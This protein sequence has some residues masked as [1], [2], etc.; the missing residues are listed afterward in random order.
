MSSAVRAG[1]SLGGSNTFTGGAGNDTFTFTGDGFAAAA[2]VDGGI[3]HRLQF[4]Q[5]KHWPHGQ[6]RVGQCPSTPDLWQITQSSVVGHHAHGIAYFYNG[7]A[8][9]LEQQ[10]GGAFYL[11]GGLL[12][13][14]AQGD[15]VFAGNDC[16]ID[17]DIFFQ[18]VGI[19]HLNEAI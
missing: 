19:N 13:A 4:H 8:V 17:V 6:G 14:S 9:A 15:E 7:D 12:G 11:R 16:G 10:A 3:A 5:L 18:N 1:D 2:K